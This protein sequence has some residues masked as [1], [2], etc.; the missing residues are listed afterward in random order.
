MSLFF[1]SS[2]IQSDSNLLLGLHIEICAANKKCC[3]V[4][5]IANSLKYSVT[6]ILF[7]F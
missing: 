2:K 3:F 6:K 7:D 4:K 5:A 1:L